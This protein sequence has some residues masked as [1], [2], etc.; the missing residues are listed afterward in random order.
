VQASKTKKQMKENT[1][2]NALVVYRRRMGFSQKLVSE[3]LG[4]RDATQLSRY[5]CEGVL[6]TLREAFKLGIVLR[7]PVEFLFPDLY[8]TLR[9]SI[10]QREEE[11]NLFGK[12]EDTE[13]EY[14]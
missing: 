13:A 1:N 14:P 10:R 4:H 2:K 3:L 12:A 9:L 8:N 5:E 7:V 6:P 11:K